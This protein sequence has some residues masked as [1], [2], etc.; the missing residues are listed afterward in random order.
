[1]LE[2]IIDKGGYGVGTVTFV[3]IIT[4]ADHNT[5]LGFAPGVIYIVIGAVANVLASQGLN[6]ELLSV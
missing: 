4:V 1:M 5:Q 6:S 2:D 3:P